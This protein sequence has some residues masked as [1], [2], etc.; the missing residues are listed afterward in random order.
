MATRVLEDQR[1]RRPK[2]NALS[3]R[4]EAR[5]VSRTSVSGV[6]IALALFI[7]AGDHFT[8][9]DQ[10]FSDRTRLIKLVALPCAALGLLLCD[11]RQIWRS[12][13]SFALLGFLLLSASSVTW[14]AN[15]KQGVFLS[16]GFALPMILIVLTLPTFP[17]KSIVNALRRFS[18]GLIAF[19]A[20]DC[21]VFSSSRIGKASPEDFSALQQGFRGSFQHKNLMAVAMTIAMCVVISFEK[22][23]WVRIGSIAT[24]VALVLLTRSGTGIASL[25]VPSMFPL[26]GFATRATDRRSRSARVALVGALVM[27]VSLT[28]YL[29]IDAALALLGKDRT[30]SNRTEIW[31]WSIAAIKQ[32]PLLGYGWGGVFTDT[33]L[34]PTYTINRRVGFTAAHAHSGPLMLLLQ[35]G[36]VGLV[37]MLLMLFG[38]LRRGLRTLAAGDLHE[39][40]FLIAIPSAL[41]LAGLAE[42]TLD[43]VA[44]VWLAV[45]YALMLHPDA[46]IAKRR[47]RNHLVRSVSRSE[48]RALL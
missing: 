1:L 32:R 31:R 36:V 29:G 5:V 46:V 10:F 48:S 18:V 40:F 13:I 27:T 26:L 17:R 41:M 16:K 25:A 38:A 35:L 24:G 11:L 42:S 28:V 7:V 44:L 14:T 12:K 37:W 33:T 43:E 2:I 34:D 19:T 22:R 30:L 15:R 20:L 23:Q 4:D 3:W 8:F 6:L 39:G 47:L 45:I 21:L 9:L